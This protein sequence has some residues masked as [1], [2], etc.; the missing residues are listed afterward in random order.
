MSYTIRQAGKKDAKSFIKL[1][2]ELQ[3]FNYENALKRGDTKEEASI[4]LVL[5]ESFNVKKFSHW[6]KNLNA[7]KKQMVYLAI[8]DE[9]KEVIGFISAEINKSEHSVIEKTGYISDLYIKEQ[10]RG[11]ELASRLLKDT[12]DW[13]KLMSVKHITLN[14]D[15]NNENAIKL[16][17]KYG[18]R[19][20]MYKMVYTKR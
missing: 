17:S 18:F 16:Y 9:T 15:I 14:V 13:F 12:L 1:L 7:E 6:L 8:N 2:I 3:E 20:L 19:K 4:N 11:K 5:K 10:H